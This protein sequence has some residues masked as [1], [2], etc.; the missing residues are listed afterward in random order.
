MWRGILPCDLSHDA[1]YVAHPHPLGQ[2]TPVKTLPSCNSHIVVPTWFYSSFLFCS[3]EMADWLYFDKDTDEDS[4]LISRRAEIFRSKLIT[5][6]K[7]LDKFTEYGHHRRKGV[8]F[9]PDDIDSTYKNR[10]GGYY[11]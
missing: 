6:F 9:S 2:Q 10:I 5:S 4:D 8:L 7:L 11:I 1:F 3:L